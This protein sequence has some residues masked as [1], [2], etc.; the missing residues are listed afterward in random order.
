MSMS[1]HSTFDVVDVV[2]R[3]SCRVH[4]AQRVAEEGSWRYS[5]RLGSS[6]GGVVRCSIN[7]G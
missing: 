5:A 2:L 7:G 4:G 3:R 6:N 1:T